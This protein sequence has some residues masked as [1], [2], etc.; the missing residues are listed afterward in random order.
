M[1]SRSTAQGPRGQAGADM[2][3][4]AGEQGERIPGGATVPPHGGPT[5]PRGNTRDAQGTPT[6]RTRAAGQ[7]RR[8][9]DGGAAHQGRGHARIAA[10]G[11]PTP[12]GHYASAP[13]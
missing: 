5:T 9:G 8:G 13:A 4:G 3:P 12:R 10:R 1:G 6:P 7:G 11:T 2:A